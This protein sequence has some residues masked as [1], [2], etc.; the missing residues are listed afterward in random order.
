MPRLLRALLLTSR[1]A[2]TTANT[3]TAMHCLSRTPATLRRGLSDFADEA[4]YRGAGWTPR[5]RCTVFFDAGCPLCVKEISVYRDLAA[6]TTFD[7]AKELEFVDCRLD[8]PDVARRGL[9]T[10]DLLRRLHCLDQHDTMHRGAPAFVELWRRLPYWRHLAFVCETVPGVMTVAD[11]VYERFSAATFERR[12]KIAAE[13]Q[14]QGKVSKCGVAPE[15]E[16]GR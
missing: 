11:F 10:L 3:A 6:S 4:A 15:K 16:P 9:T 8:H 2:A 1:P 14:A 13:A 7:R 12:Q 5:D